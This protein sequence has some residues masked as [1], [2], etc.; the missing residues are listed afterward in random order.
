MIELCQTEKVLLYLPQNYTLY[1]QIW[2]S[3]EVLHHVLAL[4]KAPLETEG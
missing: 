1:N 4:F 2:I 3:L